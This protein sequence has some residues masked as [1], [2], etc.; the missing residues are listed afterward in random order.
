MLDLLCMRC[1]IPARDGAASE[2]ADDGAEDGDA[3]GQG[4]SS[5][6]QREASLRRGRLDSA[7]RVH[8]QPSTSSDIDTPTRIYSVSQINLTG[9]CMLR[10]TTVPIMAAMVAAL[11]AAVLLLPAAVDAAAATSAVGNDVASK[12]N[13]V[14]QPT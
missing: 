10:G 8:R 11:L 12:P 4:V 5:A 13:I 2:G 7:A 9:H 1:I 3:R 6:L 14:R